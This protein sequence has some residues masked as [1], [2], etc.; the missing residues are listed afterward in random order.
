M[1]KQVGLTLGKTLMV[2][3]LALLAFLMTVPAFAS[4]AELVIP[5]LSSV[6]F[7][8]GTNGHTLLLWGLLVCAFGLSLAFSNSVE[9]RSY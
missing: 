8:G 4:E 6:S 2:L 1:K 7:L 3:G 5:D 9:L